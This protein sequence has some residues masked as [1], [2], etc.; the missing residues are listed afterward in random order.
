MALGRPV[1]RHRRITGYHLA[2]GPRR[3]WKL[4]AKRMRAWDT[5]C[6]FDTSSSSSCTSGGEPRAQSA[7]LD[8]LTKVVGRQ[9]HSLTGVDL[10]RQDAVYFRIQIRKSML[11][12]ALL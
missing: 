1:G 11:S 6:G 5:S 12:T 2:W 3:W 9:H 8:K 10:L 4:A 7:V